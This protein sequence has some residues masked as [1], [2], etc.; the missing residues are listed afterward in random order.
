MAPRRARK[1]KATVEAAGFLVRFVPGG[2]YHLTDGRLYTGVHRRGAGPTIV[3]KLLPLAR[4]SAE[5]PGEW[6]TM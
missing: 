2:Y 1:A 6:V 3:E 4:K 5:T